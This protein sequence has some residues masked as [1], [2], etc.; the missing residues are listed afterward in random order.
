MKRQIPLAVCF[1][2]GLF[3]ALQYFSPHPGPAYFYERLL[4]WQ[5][6]IGFFA[7]G[8]GLIILWITDLPKVIKQQPG[9]RWPAHRG[10][11][12]DRPLCGPIRDRSCGEDA[13]PA[14]SLA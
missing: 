12:R 7:L 13:A 5:I 11:W 14:G 2:T 4:N 6:V 3:F 1:L 8:L 9:W 10:I